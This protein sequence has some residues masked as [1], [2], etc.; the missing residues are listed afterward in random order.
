MTQPSNLLRDLGRA[1][2]RI[3]TV[4]VAGLGLAVPRMFWS[5]RVR[6]VRQWLTVTI[7]LILAPG[8]LIAHTV[9]EAYQRADHLELQAQVASIAKRLSH[10]I[11]REV[12][13]TQALGL[14]LARIEPLLRAEPDRLKS[15]FVASLSQERN[16]DL[17]ML[18]T[19]ATGRQL[20]NTRATTDADLPRITDMTGL[21][22]VLR[23]RR[24]VVRLF[25]SGSF[26]GGPLYVVIV[27]IL[28]DDRV[29]RIIIMHR[30]SDL[31]LGIIG[32][33]LP[34]G[35]HATIF[36]PDGRPFQSS[37]SQ[38]TPP[39][40]PNDAARGMPLTQVSNSGEMV[41]SYVKIDQADWTLAIAVAN[42]DLPGRRQSLLITIQTA[43]VALSLIVAW[44]AAQR[45]ARPVALVK[46]SAGEI[47]NG[48]H[49]ALRDVRS[50]NICRVAKTLVRTSDALRRSR[51]PGYSI[52]TSATNAIYSTII[53]A[54]DAII[55]TDRD[56]RVTLFNKAAQSMFESTDDMAKGNPIERFLSKVMLPDPCHR[57]TTFECTGHRGAGN[58][59][60]CDVSVARSAEDHEHYFSFIIR[61]IMKQHEAAAQNARLAVV[62]ASSADAI[63]SLGPDHTV[64]SWNP[65]AEHIFGYSAEEIVGKSYLVM[66][67]DEKRDEYL[68]NCERIC[69]GQ[70]VSLVADRRHKDGH[71]I[72][73]EI[74]SAPLRDERGV[75]I[76]I[77]S[78]LR[79]LSERTTAT[80]TANRLAA[81]VEASADPIIGL[82]PDGTIATWNPAARRVFGYSPDEVVGKSLDVLLLPDDPDG[83]QDKLERVRRA[84]LSTVQ[85]ERV[86]KD[87]SRVAVSITAAPIRDASQHVT[88]YA[89]V[90]RDV[91]ENRRH[92][93]QMHI[94]M[95]E[96]SHRAKN[97]LT[98]ITAMA[99]S[100]SSSAID[101]AVFVE[102]FSARIHGLARSHDLLVK[103]DWSSASLKS[104]I[105]SQLQPFL[106]KGSN[107]LFL[108]G[109]D[110]A[111]TPA[112]A[113]MIGLALHELATNSAKYGALTTATGSISVTW[114]VENHAL[115]S[116]HLDLIW[117]EMGGPAVVE[118]S[119]A[120]FGREVLEEMIAESLDGSTELTFPEGGVIWQ[121][122][123]PLSALQ[124]VHTH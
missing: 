32:Q 50:D 2:S 72:A 11:G 122:R 91:S 57:S 106:F 58:E 84:G 69:S 20:L 38:G 37:G 80:L 35:W 36:D 39:V 8:L 65:S 115:Q 110:I 92:E 114:T 41:T 5:R 76:G 123:A 29:E 24:P 113:Q 51:E 59:F 63:V 28:N 102:S 49:P 45:I 3:F 109:D 10:V 6:A 14:Q 70:T 104:L 17:H 53:S 12:D 7:L 13:L 64:L 77:S 97:L 78:V 117:N 31:L 71:L 34:T 60:A 118:P 120:G 121:L 108:D 93:Q 67:P 61:D 90:Y 56:G 46:R 73:V 15:I 54:S 43:A 82:M 48:S 89:V 55:C 22:L 23:E 26:S 105:E 47:G 25:S 16:H 74:S 4:G 111:V 98:V 100:M 124:A 42:H 85:T 81:I 119:G 95:R 33:E 68:R 86:R 116:A 44:S 66:I 9:L 62:V 40:L 103:K 21:E 19:D 75:V 94:V 88:G 101:I 1:G 30:S 52:I 18:L 112:A 79:D 107:R 27:P 99:R 87:G 96:L 83:L